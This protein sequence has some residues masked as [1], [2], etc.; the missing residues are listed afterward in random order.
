MQA[1]EERAAEA[2]AHLHELQAQV[3]SLAAAARDA[4]AGAGVA[5]SALAA[6]RQEAVKEREARARHEDVSWVYTLPTAQQGVCP[7]GRRGSGGALDGDGVYDRPPRVLAAHQCHVFIH[8]HVNA[9]LLHA[10]RLNCLPCLRCVLHAV[11][12]PIMPGCC[13]ADGRQPD[14]CVQAA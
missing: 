12:L 9:R 8:P 13:S 11:R 5:G 1:A 7:W 6:A 4:E 2:H 3:D 10:L 14:V